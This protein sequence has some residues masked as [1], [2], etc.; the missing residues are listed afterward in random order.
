MKR[1]FW[2]L[3]LGVLTSNTLASE[4]IKL[5]DGR[6]FIRTDRYTLSQVQVREDQLAPLETVIT[7]GFGSNVITVGDAIQELLSGS[8]YRW[9]IENERSDQLLNQLELPL[10]NRDLGPIKLRDALITVVGRAWELEVNELTR[11]ISFNVAQTH[12]GQ[13]TL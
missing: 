3:C 6:N 4:L 11:Q 12:V 10:V 2:I 13:R 5:N 9:V 8:G 1:L 7:L